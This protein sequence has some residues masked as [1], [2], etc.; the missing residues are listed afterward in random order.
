MSNEGFVNNF[1]NQPPWEVEAE[2]GVKSLDS[3]VG[4]LEKLLTARD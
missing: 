1:R 2:R 4:S 3:T